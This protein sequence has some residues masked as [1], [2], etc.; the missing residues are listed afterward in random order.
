MTKKLEK[1]D[2]ADI[3]YLKKLG[4]QD[5]MP[6]LLS[7]LEAHVIKH[8]AQPFTY[9]FKDISIYISASGCRQFIRNLNYKIQI[10]GRLLNEENRF[11]NLPK[12]LR[13][14][15][16]DPTIITSLYP[17]LRNRLHS[18]ECYTL[19]I[20]ASKGRDYFVKELGLGKAAMK[21]L[22][23]LFIKRKAGHLFSAS[24]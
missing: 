20:I 4:N 18:A 8:G 17:V 9:K 13:N 22:D 7:P 16:D 19:A 6:D 1:L 3:A 14:Q 21:T 10:I 5:L 11:G 23:A 2:K 15:L 24:K 12:K